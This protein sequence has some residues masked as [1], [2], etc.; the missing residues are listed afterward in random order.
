MRLMIVLLA[1]S[2]LACS[3]S[4]KQPA[5]AGLVCSEAGRALPTENTA[6][7]IQEDNW[8]FVL[9]GD[10]WKSVNK[11]VPDIK[12]IFVNEKLTTLIFLGKQATTDSFPDYIINSLRAFKASGV[13]VISAKSITIQNKPF[14][15]VTGMPDDKARDIWMW[16]TLDKGFGYIFSC[17]VEHSPDASPTAFDVCNTIANSIEIK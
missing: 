8:K 7:V 17:V 9:S 16:V 14:I 11:E 4:V 15:L 5:D 10:N 13:N 12:V 1:L 3:Q 2:I 6:D